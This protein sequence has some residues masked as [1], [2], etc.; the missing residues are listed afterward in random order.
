MQAPGSTVLD[1]ALRA[2]AAYADVI[3]R[4]RYAEDALAA[5]A[6]GRFSNRR[7]CWIR[8]D[9]MSLRTWPA[10]IWKSGSAF[11]ILKHANNY[12]RQILTV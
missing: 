5:A 6:N 9:V 10:P 8:P 7:L 3:L 11:F 4:T 1:A 2:N 12:A